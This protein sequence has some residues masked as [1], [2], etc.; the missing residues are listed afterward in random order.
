M[1]L[2]RSTNQYRPERAVQNG[3]VERTAR[4]LAAALLFACFVAPAGAQRINSANIDQQRQEIH[5]RIQHGIASGLITPD[6]AQTLAEREQDIANLQAHYPHNGYVST[7]QQEQLR[8]EL[9]ALRADVERKIRNNRMTGQPD[10]YL[11]D[12]AG[13]EEQIGQRIDRGIAS[14]LITRTEAQ[15]LRQRETDLYRREAGFRA[16][17][18]ITDS[19]RETLQREVDALNRDVNRLLNNVRIQR[20]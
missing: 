18:R 16:D 2:I 9:D 14:G 12:I 17:G 3:K 8:R 13:R 6:E 5:L 19:E 11:P 4:V 15:R 1:T 7:Y 20:R 10:G